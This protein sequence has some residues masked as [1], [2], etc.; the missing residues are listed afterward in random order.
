MNTM[1][2]SGKYAGSVSSP[3]N[4]A[5]QAIWRGVALVTVSYSQIPQLESPGLR[6][7]NTIFVPSKETSGWFT[8][9]WTPPGPLVREPVILVS[10]PLGE[11]LS[12]MKRSPP[13]AFV[14][15]SVGLPRAPVDRLMKA[16]GTSPPTVIELVS[17]PL[18]ADK[19]AATT[20]SVQAMLRVLRVWLMFASVLS[21]AGV[22]V[23]RF[24]A[25]PGRVVHASVAVDDHRVDSRQRLDEPDALLC[26]LD[27]HALGDAF[28]GGGVRADDGDAA[29]AARRCSGLRIEDVVI[30][31]AVRFE[32]ALVVSGRRNRG[33]DQGNPR[34]HLLFAPGILD[35]D[36]PRPPAL[37]A[38]HPGVA[39]GHHQRLRDAARPEQADAVVHG[40]A[41]GDAAEVDPDPVAGEA[42]GPL[43]T[44]QPDVPVVN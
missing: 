9:P 38:Q 43:A 29:H 22:R 10:V 11:D 8:S 25:Q 24:L 40:M 23:G 15:A 21:L 31:H 27:E 39:S 44:V 16:M 13:G 33:V 7:A 20:A 3:W 6:I 17:V 5:S 18:Q 28:G 32:V 30:A 1:R 2:P 36:H 26:S 19:P 14:T 34:H 41:L 37:V 12:R 4:A 35:A 42:D